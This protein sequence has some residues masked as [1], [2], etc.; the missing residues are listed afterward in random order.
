MSKEVYRRLL[1]VVYVIWC[2]APT[3]TMNAWVFSN[4]D[5][6][7]VLYLTG[8]YIKLHVHGK[9]TY[10]NRWNLAAALAQHG[11]SQRALSPCA[12]QDF[13]GIPHMPGH[14][15][16]AQGHGGEA[17]LRGFRKLSDAWDKKHASRVAG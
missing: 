6:F 15:P 2:L 3:F 4:M 10:N 13:S 16:A 5:L 14:R 7:L 12:D 17:F 11:L 9:T 1:L 8:A